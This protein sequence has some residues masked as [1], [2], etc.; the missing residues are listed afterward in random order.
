[1][2]M[3][4]TEELKEA[5]A[6]AGRMREKGEDPCHVAKALLSLNYRMRYLERVLET[7]E[8]Y[9]H[10]GLSAQDHIALQRAVEEARHVIARNKGG[11][12]SSFG[13]T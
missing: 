13:L 6:E 10:F 11:D 12:D 8:H 4:T 1:M 7:A 9:I 2:G 5:L 3:P